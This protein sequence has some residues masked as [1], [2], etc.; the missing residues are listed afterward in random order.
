MYV[1]GTLYAKICSPIFSKTKRDD[2]NL[3]KPVDK[4][5]LGIE[6]IKFWANSVDT[7]PR[8]STFCWNFFEKILEYL[9]NIIEDLRLSRNI[10]EQEANEVVIEYYLTSHTNSQYS[11]EDL[12][13]KIKYSF[14]P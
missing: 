3:L 4:E 10:T 6:T 5:Y 12:K 14:T 11:E 8:Y 1:C 9:R 7:V 13:R 2:P